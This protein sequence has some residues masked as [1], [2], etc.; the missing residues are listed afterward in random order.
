MRGKGSETSSSSLVIV[1]RKMLIA[2]IVGISL[3]SFGLGYFF[4]YGGSSATRMVKKVEAD[5]KIVAS[6]EKTVLDSTGKPTM[7][8][9][10]VIPGAV[11]KEPPLKPKLEERS[12]VVT[13][14]SGETEKQKKLAETTVPGKNSDSVLKKDAEESEKTTEKSTEKKPKIKPK[15]GINDNPSKDRVQLVA[16]AKKPEVK[17]AL[18]KPLMKGA[19]GHA[20]KSYVLQVGAFE[21][22]QKAERLR[23]NLSAKGYTVSI[24]TVSPGTSVSPV[25]SKTFSRVRLGPFATKKKVEEVHSTLKGQG[26]DGVVLP[27][28]I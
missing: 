9:P 18:K 20:R 24:T 21:D 5:N 1:S 17:P 15:S 14:L 7:V 22:P 16:K 12:E 28:A 23:K 13:N 4:G 26:M 19:K 10:T 27:G 3:F 2:G 11:P 6:E 25:P 8:A